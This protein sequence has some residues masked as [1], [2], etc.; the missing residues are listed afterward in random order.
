MTLPAHLLSR[1][2]PRLSPRSD[3]SGD[4][5][6][7]KGVNWDRPLVSVVMNCYN[8][9][10]YLR[11]AIDSVLAQ[12]Y[13]NWEV[14]FWDNHSV[15]QS[16]TIF[17]SYKDARLHYY[18]AERHTA[19]AEARNCALARCQGSLV[20]FLDVDDWWV[21]KKLEVQ[22]P[23]FGDD[24]VGMSCGNFILVNERPGARRSLSPIY[25]SL[26]AGHVLD[27]LFNDPFVHFSTFMAK[28]QAIEDLPYAFDPRF[29]IIEDFDLLV[30]L[31][32]RWRM[33][34]VQQP[35]AYYRWH[36]TNAGYR[37]H[38][39]I[40]EEY[41]QWMDDAKNQLIYTEQEHFPKFV[42]K[43]KLYEVLR[44]LYLGQRRETW[45]RLRNVDTGKRLKLVIAL[46]LPLG[47]VR[48]WMARKAIR[49]VWPGG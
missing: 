15:D 7:V 37:T 20:A 9:A 16:A 45:R 33:A 40:S 31:S 12:T 21:P 38:F 30:R 5:S 26:P 2:Y 49:S 47:L 34:S 25:R 29:E 3:V 39:L 43:V 11:S 6:V 19:L 17:K 10:Q 14:V 48:R 35:I 8:G 41:N 27:D 44:L 18:Y 36:Q 28:S 24:D 1:R 23:L 32:V 42:A 4:V 22:V 46:L 13:E